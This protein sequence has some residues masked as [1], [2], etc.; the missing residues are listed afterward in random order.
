[1]KKRYKL[2]NWVKTSLIILAG[3]LLVIGFIAIANE[4]VNE[5]ESNEVLEN[6]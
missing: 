5:I 4:R 3:S 1:M 2:R 6:E